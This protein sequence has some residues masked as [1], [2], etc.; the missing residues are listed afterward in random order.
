[1]IHHSSFICTKYRGEIYHAAVHVYCALIVDTQP[2][3]YPGKLEHSKFRL[4]ILFSVG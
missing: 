3:V 2:I 1:M 4:Y